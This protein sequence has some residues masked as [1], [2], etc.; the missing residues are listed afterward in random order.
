MISRSRSVPGSAAGP[1]D[2]IDFDYGPVGMFIRVIGAIGVTDEAG[3]E[4]DVS[5]PRQRL[6]LSILAANR[7]TPVAASRLAELIWPEGPPASAQTSLQVTISKLRKLLEPERKARSESTLLR[8]VGTGY[9]LDVGDQGVD[10]AVLQR[11]IA[12]AIDHPT[13]DAIAALDEARQAPVFAEFE[14]ASWA[15]PVV[16]RLREDRLSAIARYALA[17]IE[18]NNTSRLTSLLKNELARHP[19]EERL[20]GLLMLVHARDGRQADALSVFETMRRK[21]RDELGLEPTTNL[22][23]IERAILEQ[24]P[25][26]F[27]RLAPRSVRPDATDR[28]QVGKTSSPL[29]GR[30]EEVDKLLALTSQQQLVS[31]VGPAGAGKTSIA[32]EVLRQQT[33]RRT[34]FVD[35]TSVATDRRVARA[36]ADA[37]GLL[38]EPSAELTRALATSL[39]QEP[40]PL[41]LDNCENLLAG[42]VDVVAEMTSSPDVHVHVLITSRHLLGLSHESVFRL[43]PLSLPA[44]GA[45]AAEVF[46]APACQLL[47]NRAG[48]APLPEAAPAIA[49][50]SRLLDGLPLALELGAH[51]LRTIGSAEL[52]R[53]LQ[54]DRDV[55]GPADV[56]AAQRSLDG[57][58]DRSVRSL[59]ASSRDVLVALGAFS[60]PVRPEAVERILAGEHGGSVVTD[61]ISD[62]VDRSLV[63]PVGPAHERHAMSRFGLLETVRAF[64]RRLM[65]REGTTAAWNDRHV[66]L[67]ASVATESRGRR[68]G[69]H[70]AI[71]DLADEIARALDHLETGQHDGATHLQLVTNIGSY[72]YRSGRLREAMRRMKDAVELYPDV[73]PLWRGVT[74]AAAGLMSFSSG[75]FRQLDVL[76]GEAIE[77]LDGVGMPGLDLLRAAQLVARHDLDGV[78]DLITAALASNTVVGMQRAI[79][80]DV[81]AYSAWFAGEYDT[82]IERFLQQER[83]AAQAGDVFLQ[84]RAIRGR[85]LMLTYQGTPESGALLVQQSIELIDDWENDRS[86]AQCMAIRSAVKRAIGRGDD[87]RQDALGAMRRASTRFD[88]NPMMVAV[89]VMT[90]VE[91]NAG[92]F[93]EVARMTGWL[94][95]IC[96]A[97]GMYLPAESERIASEAERAARES[98]GDEAWIELRSSGAEHGLAGLVEGL[99]AVR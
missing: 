81:A 55:A 91:A 69:D 48:L 40:T 24:D 79:A 23:S 49:E 4:T 14:N 87:A 37:V 57:A 30:D 94:R 31:I 83:A 12:D 10:L 3:R 42:V 26:V 16:D 74:L 72:W 46:A 11:R 33:R 89:P 19:Y 18:A 6:V 70:L 97:T 28:S 95:G 34:F 9:C 39:R 54:A 75:E 29:V 44:E 52:L 93:D 15:R 47:V 53:H 17:G 73:D 96:A 58:L 84:G 20:A 25:T 61:A 50:I 90:S 38:E 27:G 99:Q 64:I 85:G 1:A 71:S 68:R 67:V 21:L 36:V 86:A 76:L 35:L 80:L 41:V 60:G 98:L 59:S 51:R 77:V 8:T 7:G 13:D 78:E 88:G 43:D 82:A 32:R 66:A 2:E 62:L 56:P 65:E 5:S 45:A 92:R 63:V 22:R